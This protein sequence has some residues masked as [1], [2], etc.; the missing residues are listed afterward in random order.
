MPI[1]SFLYMNIS[2]YVSWNLRVNYDWTFNICVFSY[3]RRRRRRK[4]K[5][6]MEEEEM[7]TKLIS[8]QCILQFCSIQPLLWYPMISAFWYSCPCVVSSHIVSG[9]FPSGSVVKKS[10][11][12]TGDMGSI[13]GLGWEDPLEKEMASH[14]SILDCK[15]PRTEEP[16]GLQSMG[17]QKYQTWLS[18]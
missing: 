16:G 14:S 10:L 11:A 17:S 3:W 4:K 9:L 5:E 6:E 12:N 15:V 8:P 2:T 1:S 13:P 18:D 7:Y